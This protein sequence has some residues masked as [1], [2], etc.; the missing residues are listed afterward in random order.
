MILWLYLNIDCDS[1]FKDYKTF[2]FVETVLRK[3]CESGLF[4][5]IIHFKYKT[6]LTIVYSLINLFIKE[7]DN[8]FVEL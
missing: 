8:Y 5:Y 4:I 1:Y 3:K 2:E 6:D 7:C